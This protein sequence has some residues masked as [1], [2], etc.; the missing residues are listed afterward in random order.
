[1]IFGNTWNLL[2]G[3]GS[4]SFPAFNVYSTDEAATVLSEIPG[5]AAESLEISVEE[6][7]LSIGF[8]RTSDKLDADQGERLLRHERPS[9]KF[10]RRIALPFSVE[11]DEVQASMNAGLLRIDLPRAKEQRP[12][13]IAVSVA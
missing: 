8:S 1:M 6:D 11:R 7:V 10:Q 13:T 12:R 5:V 2:N 4:G 3:A 9:G